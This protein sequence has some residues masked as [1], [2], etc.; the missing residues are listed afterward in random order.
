MNTV[1]GTGCTLLL[2]SLL[3]A[4]VYLPVDPGLRQ[5]KDAMLHMGDVAEVYE[6]TRL[7]EHLYACEVRLHTSKRATK[8]WTRP[9]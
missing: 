7:S 8:T 4:C 3:S 6:C 9:Q 1:Y 5:A 2:S